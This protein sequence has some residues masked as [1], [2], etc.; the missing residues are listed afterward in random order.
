MFYSKV[1]YISRFRMV[2]KPNEIL[3][4][5]IRKGGERERAELVRTPE[6]GTGS[7]R[8]ATWICEVRICFFPLSLSLSLLYIFHSLFVTLTYVTLLLAFRVFTYF[9]V[10]DEGMRRRIAIAFSFR[11]PSGKYFS[12]SRKCNKN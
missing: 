2:N 12:L 11:D 10:N 7:M 1:I 4:R 6:S 3:L 5:G 8:D 9:R